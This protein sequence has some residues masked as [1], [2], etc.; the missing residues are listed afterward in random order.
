MKLLNKNFIFLVGS[1]LFS[2]FGTAIS[3]FAI[4]L[5]VLDKTGSMGIF[6][7]VL[8]LSMISRIIFLPFGGIVADRLPKKKLMI[9]MDFSYLIMVLAIAIGVVKG[10]TILIMGI[11][12]I[13]LGVVSSFETPVVQSAIPLVCKEEQIPKANGIINSVA[14]LSN[15]LAPVLAGI[16]YNFNKAYNIFIVSGLFFLIAVI[17]E[18]F[19]TIKQKESKKTGSSPVNIV[20]EDTKETLVYL[21][22]NMLIVRICLVTFLLNMVI[23]SF[24]IVVL[25]YTVRVGWSIG[26]ELYGVMN[27]L[28]AIGGLSGSIAVSTLLSKI[29]GNNIIK[30]LLISSFIFLLLVIPYSGI[31][32][33]LTSFWI[34]V[35][36]ITLLEGIFTMVSI[37]LISFVQL[38]T[39]KEIMG[40]VMSFMMMISMLAMPLGQIVYGMLGKLIIG[41][42]AV[43]IIMV[44]AFISILITI[45][46]RNIFKEVKIVT[47]KSKI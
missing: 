46:S 47:E 42:W 45:Y 28:F 5:Y 16:I 17:C 40:R 13:I 12:S 26:D 4:S 44:I 39:D 33:N 7:L 10:N 6:S 41:K 23:S 3:Q 1:Q 25:P 34:M 35:A 19:L 14:M 15:I 37:Q 27:T 24:T 9:V 32:N 8:S 21:K 43:I 38:I 22:D 36:L 11:I 29:N 2:V 30:M 20:V 31:Y 18:I